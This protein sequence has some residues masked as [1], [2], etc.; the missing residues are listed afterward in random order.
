MK[1]NGVL[2]ISIDKLLAIKD[3]RQH[4][5]E[6]IR[7]GIASADAGELVRLALEKKELLK[8][9]ERKQPVVV[10]AGK[11]AVAMAEAFTSTLEMTARGS[12]SYTHLTLPTILRV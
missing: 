10:A 11:A 3:L 4:V 2:P 8:L 1:P 9:F 12:V 5:H 6:I 7:V